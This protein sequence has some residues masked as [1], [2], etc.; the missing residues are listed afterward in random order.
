M[1]FYSKSL[2]G[3]DVQPDAMRL[4]Q[5][6]RT[7]VG[8]QLERIAA[9][10]LPPNIFNNSKIQEWNQLSSILKEWLQTLGLKKGIV[11]L[12][13]PQY[14]IRTQRMK[15]PSTLK[16]EE[17]QAAI[18]AYLQPDMAGAN[19]SLS[20]DY[21]IVDQQFEEMEIV[22]AA[23]RKGYLL[24]YK[25]CVE[26]TGLKVSIFDVNAYA[27]YR[28]LQCSLN[29][30]AILHVKRE[31]TELVVFN[32]Q[33]LIFQQQWI[34]A[35]QE[36]LT[37]QLQESQRLFSSV[38]GQ[39]AWQQVIFCA[40]ENNAINVNELSLILNCAVKLPMLSLPLV[41]G[42]QDNLALLANHLSDYLVAYGLAMREILPW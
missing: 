22:F 38:T 30:S 39:L 20:I 9:C 2:I 4:I 25:E 35:S 17:I 40:P 37:K 12:G 3:L 11:A 16:D 21:Y 26:K 42:S 41:A 10:L 19:E 15:L 34:T 36:A 33:E 28:V 8:Y 6:K 27:L 7:R 31:V 23:T 5:L 24:Q 18:L 1:P 14:M 29:M 13:L 32:G